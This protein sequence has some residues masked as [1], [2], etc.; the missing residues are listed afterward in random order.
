MKLGKFRLTKTSIVVSVFVL[1]VMVLASFLY[2]Q[3]WVEVSMG[4]RYS[5][6]ALINPHLALE[7]YLEKR[8]IS[9][10]KVG[11]FDQRIQ[12]V[13][14]S[15][16]T[17]YLPVRH[18]ILAPYQ[19]D[20]LLGWVNEGG[21]LIYRPSRV[22]DEDG[23]RENDPVLETVG[24]RFVRNSTSETR[25]LDGRTKSFHRG[26]TTHEG[27]LRK[28]TLHGEQS[29]VDLSPIF[30]FAGEADH[31]LAKGKAVMPIEYGNGWVILISGDRQWSN[32][33]FLCHDNSKLLYE[34]ITFDRSLPMN[35]AFMWLEPDEFVWLTDRLWENYPIQIL[36]L[37]AIFVLWVRMVTVR[38]TKPFPSPG[39]GP[40]SIGEYVA[41][42]SRFQWQSA[43]D[44]ELLAEE[45]ARIMK[46]LASKRLEDAISEV[47]EK[48]GL[49]RD[50]VEFAM[51]GDPSSRQRRFVA[52]MK[53]LKQIRQKL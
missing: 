1:I 22:F 44:V 45:R 6:A 24:A 15:G 5:D 7:T 3:E 31:M 12:D 14:T 17:I 21:T 35:A 4:R 32:P 19:A 48:T 9:F 39:G 10:S 29:V 43:R 41:S 2:F 23:I 28:V 26:C 37:L 34:L 16:T 36:L 50:D 8:G 33:L 20:A 47:V 46:K 38:Q 53:K 30:S 42:I 27:A 25:Q 18:G 13:E 52:I 40:R 11:D 49:E 51:S